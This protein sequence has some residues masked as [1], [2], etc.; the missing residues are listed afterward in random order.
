MVV[1]TACG[2]LHP[3]QRGAVLEDKDQEPRLASSPIN[4]MGEDQERRVSASRRDAAATDTVRSRSRRATW[5]REG[6]SMASG[7]RRQSQSRII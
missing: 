3:H 6:N 5:Y 7:C 4:K 2:L 1:V